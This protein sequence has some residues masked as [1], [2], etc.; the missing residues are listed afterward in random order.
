MEA[1]KERRRA[2]VK[3]AANRFFNEF[4]LCAVAMW[5]ELRGAENCASDAQLSY[6]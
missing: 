3:T 1:V 4:L 5:L 6:Q 2:A